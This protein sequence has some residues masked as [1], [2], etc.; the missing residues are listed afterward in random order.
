MPEPNQCLPCAITWAPVASAIATWFAVLV[1]LFRETVFLWWRR[2]RFEVTIRPEPPDCNKSE[3]QLQTG[4]M[5][6]YDL[7][8]WVRNVGRSTATRVQVVAAE[9]QRQHADGVFRVERR[10]LPMNLLWSHTGV[11]FSD[12][13]AAEMG[14]HCE[15]GII[16]K[17]GVIDPQIIPPSNLPAEKTFLQ[18]ETE[19]RPYTGNSSL[20]PGT[21][22]LQ[23]LVAASNAKPKAF[24]VSLSIVGD[25]HDDE[26]QMLSRNIGAKVE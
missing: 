19:V 8:L 9:L 7:R 16:Y 1:A 14:Q 21:Y 12:G 4:R 11:V 10:F 6:A 2:P 17:P 18:L 25:W 20:E 23:I 3:F 22:R 26:G 13:I 5:P 15:L 24:T